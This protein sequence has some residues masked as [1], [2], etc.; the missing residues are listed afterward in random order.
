MY[1]DH[2][3]VVT[4]TLQRQTLGPRQRSG[5]TFIPLKISSS[6]HPLFQYRLLGTCGF[7]PVKHWVKFRTWFKTTHKNNPG[8]KP[9]VDGLI[10]SDVIR[11][12]RNY[13]LDSPA[14]VEQ[15][16]Y[17]VHRPQKQFNHHLEPSGQHY[18]RCKLARTRSAL[19][20]CPKA[21]NQFLWTTCMESHGSGWSRSLV[22][23]F[24]KNVTLFGGS[25]D[26]FVMHPNL[27][28]INWDGFAINNG[29]HRYV[30]GWWSS[31]VCY[32]HDEISTEQNSGWR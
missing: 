26:M 3:D 16:V 7:A 21:K 11:C 25:L 10:P 4:F 32:I 22:V 23:P 14:H 24:F 12:K 31:V 13:P 28:R 19:Y 29:L 8:F 27:I 2:P 5:V 1:A 17:K 15:M 6:A 18:P 9:Y 30:L 20:R